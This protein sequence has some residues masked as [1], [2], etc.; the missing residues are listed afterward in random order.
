MSVNQNNQDKLHPVTIKVNRVDVSFPDHKTSGLA[1][2]QAAI[3][4]GVNNVTLEFDLFRIAG[5]TQH[6]IADGEEKTL[7]D[8]EEF[9]MLRPDHDS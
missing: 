9:R 8:G 4:Q 6:K 1:I 2:K 7:H 3:A 5:D